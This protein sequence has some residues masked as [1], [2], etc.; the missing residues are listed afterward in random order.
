MVAVNPG[1][2]RPLWATV[3]VW[4]AAAT[5]VPWFAARASLDRPSLR[6]LRGLHFAKFLGTGHGRTF[7]PRDADWRHWALFATWSAPEH[8]DAFDDSPLV[9]RR[10]AAS[11]ERL[12]L[13]LEPVTWR[14]SWDGRA[15]FGSAEAR[16]EHRGPEPVAALTRARLALGRHTAFRRAVPAI[17]A[18]LRTSPGKIM[19]FGVGENPFGRQG[20]FS[21][22][23]D[24]D[25]MRAFAHDSPAHRRAVRLTPRTRW[26]AEEL[27]ATFRVQRMSGS[28]AGT[29]YGSTAKA[30]G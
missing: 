11:E 14:G 7:S 24:A 9:R 16:G 20:T 27:F 21:V 4:G 15:P 8:A 19:A 2:A 29:T 30:A 6:G 5:W 28:H 13:V 18:E 17:A 1:L 25:A 12:R 3:H 10:D 22:W 26:Y 23:H